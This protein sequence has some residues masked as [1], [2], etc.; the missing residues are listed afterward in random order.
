MNDKHAYDEYSLYDGYDDYAWNSLHSNICTV[1]WIAN[2]LT[3]VQSKSCKHDN[4]LSH[5]KT[6]ETLS[7]VCMIKSLNHL[8]SLYI[9]NH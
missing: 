9:N 8:Q 1:H 5:L 4:S 6:A 7:P 3:Q 2:A